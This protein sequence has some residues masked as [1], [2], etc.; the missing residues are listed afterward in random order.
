MIFFFRQHLKHKHINKDHICYHNQGQHNQLCK[1]KDINQTRLAEETKV[2]FL[3]STSSFS[4][5][6]K[7]KSMTVID[8]IV[9]NTKTAQEISKKQVKQTCNLRHK[10]TFREITQTILKTNLFIKAT[11][12][13]MK[14]KSRKS[15]SSDSEKYLSAGSSFSN[16]S[17]ENEI[18]VSKKVSPWLESSVP[19][20]DYTIDNSE[21]NT[22]S[23]V[24]ENKCCKSRIIVRKR[25]EYRTTIPP[26][27]VNCS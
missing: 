19:T 18:F 27:K 13:T 26:R 17:E 23:T 21:N 4:L 2:I 14:T 22:I 12:K 24:E 3:N 8:E 7:L 10:K 16:T 25:Q 11:G 20:E 6:T 1:N 5:L 15:S 9:K